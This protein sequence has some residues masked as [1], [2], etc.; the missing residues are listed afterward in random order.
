MSAKRTLRPVSYR[1]AFCLGTDMIESMIALVGTM[2]IL[3]MN[4]ERRLMVIIETQC[5]VLYYELATAENL[6]SFLAFP[7]LIEPTIHPFY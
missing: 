2:S 1:N 5:I 3:L 6:I 7:P 4:L